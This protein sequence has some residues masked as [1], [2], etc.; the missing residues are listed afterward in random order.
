MKVRMI[1]TARF[2][3]EVEG[4]HYIISP[5]EWFRGGKRASI[6]CYPATG[7]KRG[8]ETLYSAP[9]L[10]CEQ[11]EDETIDSYVSRLLPMVEKLS[12]LQ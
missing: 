9:K 5:E 1:K 11:G 8:W 10:P 3:V 7:N 4:W 2:E 6:F 12:L